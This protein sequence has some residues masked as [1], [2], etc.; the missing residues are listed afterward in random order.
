MRMSTPRT[1]GLKE[2][3]RSR[4][5]T[6]DSRRWIYIAVRGLLSA[7]GISAHA[8]YPQVGQLMLYQH[9]H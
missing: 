7:A 2:V 8:E 1:P 5:M 9:A 3:A 4:E 6:F